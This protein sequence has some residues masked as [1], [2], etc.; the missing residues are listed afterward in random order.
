MPYIQVTTR[1][2][3]SCDHCGFS[4]TAVGEDMSME[5]FEKV[6]EVF[7]CDLTTIGGGEP[8]LNPKILEMVLIAMAHTNGNGP[9]FM[10][11]NGSREREA[12]LLAKLAKSSKGVFDC[13]L[14][15]DKFHDP[16]S[17]EVEYAFMGKY[18]QLRKISP[19]GRAKEN[20]IYTAYE[21]DFPGLNCF[22]DEIIIKPNGD[23]YV[24][25]CNDSPKIGNIMQER[26]IDNLHKL[27]ADKDYERVC[28]KA[29]KKYSRRYNRL[30]KKEAV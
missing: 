19:N 7:E 1:C 16:I 25:G 26:G 12:L 21:Y 2:N 10:V 28:W 22:C 6:M 11:T 18:N 14:S 20:G 30:Y 24:C 13:W 9:V 23:M 15:M 3:M 5:V 27:L 4:C 8:T 29:M 17:A